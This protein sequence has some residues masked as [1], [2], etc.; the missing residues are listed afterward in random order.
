MPHDPNRQARERQ[1]TQRR[2]E[3]ARRQRQDADRF[4][5]EAKRYFTKREENKKATENRSGGLLGR[6]KRFV[7]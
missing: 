2:E 4:N 1:E 3:I 5:A 6:I 7:K